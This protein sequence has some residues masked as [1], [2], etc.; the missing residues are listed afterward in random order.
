VIFAARKIY[1]TIF[2][3]FPPCLIDSR[4]F[5]LPLRNERCIRRE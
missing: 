2:D 3:F 1:P 5:P 4:P